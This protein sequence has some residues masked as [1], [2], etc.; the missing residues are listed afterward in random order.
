MFT[1]ST[2]AMLSVVVVSF[3]NAGTVRAD[4]WAAP[5]PAIFGTDEGGGGVQDSSYRAAIGDGANVDGRAVQVGQKRKGSCHATV[6]AG[7]YSLQ[8]D[9]G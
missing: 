9:G 1:R 2:L 7:E 4:T 5:M 6:R 8:R 3:V